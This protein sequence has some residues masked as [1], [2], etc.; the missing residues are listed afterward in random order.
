MLQKLAELIR[1]FI[2]NINFSFAALFLVDH[3]ERTQSRFVPSVSIITFPFSFPARANDNIGHLGPL[4]R[5]VSSSR[6]MTLSSRY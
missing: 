1:P 2:Q 5:K 4:K 6:V 3:E